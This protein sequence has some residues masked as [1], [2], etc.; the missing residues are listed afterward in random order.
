[1]A[2]ALEIV[3]PLT[4]LIGK[5]GDELI[6]I[7]AHEVGRYQVRIYSERGQTRINYI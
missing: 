2:L 6:A 3:K 5:S 7:F 1:M 4:K